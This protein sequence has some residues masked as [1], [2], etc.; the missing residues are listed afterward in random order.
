VLLPDEPIVTELAASQ[1]LELLPLDG[2]ENLLRSLREYGFCLATLSNIAAERDR[3]ASIPRLF[4]RIDR[5]F[6][7][8]AIGWK[9]PSLKAFEFVQQALAVPAHDICMVGDRLAIDIEPAL[10]LG[11]SAI[12]LTPRSHDPV[13]ASATTAARFRHV[14]AISAVCAAACALFGIAEV[15]DRRVLSQPGADSIALTCQFIDDGN[16]AT[17]TLEVTRDVYR[18]APCLLRIGEQQYGCI[19]V[20]LGDGLVN[21]VA[22]RA[23]LQHGP[24][25]PATLVGLR[26]PAPK[27]PREN[28]REYRVK[29]LQQRSRL[30]RNNDQDKTTLDALYAQGSEN[31]EGK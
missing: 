31:H 8:H 10:A 17:M 5:H 1:R 15:R 28:A 29:L 23:V 11:W 14:H 4:S 7:S 27:P 9:K 25:T 22:P 12:L 26:F 3:S 13:G 18:E 21:V 16:F 6:P 19:A 24:G 30:Q 20:R 2:A